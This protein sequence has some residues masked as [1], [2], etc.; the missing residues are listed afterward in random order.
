M[1]LTQAAAAF[2][3]DSPSVRLRQAVIVSADYGGPFS[4]T[5]QTCTVML[6]G[7]TDP[8]KA[9][10][11]VPY[12]PHVWPRK[13]WSVWVA[14]DGRDMF[15]IANAGYT[16]QSY[17]TV[18][19]Q[20]GRTFYV[21]TKALTTNVA[22]LTIGPYSSTATTTQA[23][24][25]LLVGNNVTVSGVGAPFD[26]TFSVT[27]VTATTFSYAVTNAN[28]AS[29]SVA[30]T[31]AVQK[32]L[33]IATGTDTT[34]N[35]AAS[36]AYDGLSS[37]DVNHFV[38]IRG[39]NSG[40]GAYGNFIDN[41]NFEGSVQGWSTGFLGGNTAYMTC[42]AAQA[43]T[44]A[45]SMLVTWPAGGATVWT[46]IRGCV[47]GQTYT[48][49]AYVYVP[50]AQPAVSIGVFYAA[51]D[52][53]TSTTGAWQRIS[54]SFTATSNTHSL[55]LS[56]AS[57]GTCYI[58]SVQMDPGSTALTLD[59]YN[60]DVLRAPWTGWYELTAGAQFASNATGSRMVSILYGGFNAAVARQRTN[61]VSGAPTHVNVS[62]G[63]I[64]CSAG[65]WF[66]MQ[67]TQDS[68]GNLN[69]TTSYGPFM[70]IKYLGPALG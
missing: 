36:P 48:V 27:A 15:I 42:S 13:G 25:D 10:S 20:F 51:P 38:G 18:R 32:N 16:A 21:I 7:E 6:S 1:D 37:G 4:S 70:T 52:V 3:P 68:G 33:V 23:G 26:G 43:Q 56:A 22:T 59:T 17:P 19:L 66:T 46:F 50:A 30:P 8:N 44:G 35:F 12:A 54:S 53:A 5:P 31:G 58:D 61:A 55:T 63:T 60:R 69:L 62:T 47:P 11:G 57:A 2:A 45:N 28:I 40:Y 67:A 65:D 49:S 64:Y 24:H 41:S 9:I 39:S 14:V 29:T 34:V